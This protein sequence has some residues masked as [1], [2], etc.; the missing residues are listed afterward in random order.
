ML[1]SALFPMAKIQKQL[2]PSVD[3]ETQ[4]KCSSLR[5]EGNPVLCENVDETQNIPAW[6]ERQK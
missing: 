2:R 5:R 1:V 6:E 4:R 3:E